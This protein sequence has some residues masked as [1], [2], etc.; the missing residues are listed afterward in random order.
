MGPREPTDSLSTEEVVTAQSKLLTS[1]VIGQ[2]LGC[3]INTH[4]V[5]ANE[6]VNA[7]S[8]EELD[9]VDQTDVARGVCVSCVAQLLMAA[10]HTVHLS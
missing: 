5:A 1:W 6:Y 4:H 10:R 2:R 7:K 8:P 9:L 3:V